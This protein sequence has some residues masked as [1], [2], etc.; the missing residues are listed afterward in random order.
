MINDVSLGALSTKKKCPLNIR[1]STGT[2]APERCSTVSRKTPHRFYRENNASRFSR[3]ISV[4]SCLH[5]LNG[6][7]LVACRL[8]WRS[9][10][11]FAAVSGTTSAAGTTL[12]IR[13]QRVRRWSQRFLHWFLLAPQ[14]SLLSRAFA[15]CIRG[16]RRD[17]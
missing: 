13:S 7:H 11:S 6:P 5:S 3:T 17:S 2:V 15:C 9:N 10:S 4:Q 14:H 1:K 12:R 8:R 16:G